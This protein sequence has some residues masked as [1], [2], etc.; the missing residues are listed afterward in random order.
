VLQQLVAPYPAAIGIRRVH[1][2]G[3]LAA[4]GTVDGS[5]VLVT[6]LR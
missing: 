4:T 3:S 6:Q 1:T 5:T 2:S